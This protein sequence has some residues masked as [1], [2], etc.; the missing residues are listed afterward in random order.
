MIPMVSQGMRKTRVGNPLK[1][2]FI[3]DAGGDLR[4]RFYQELRSKG[5]RW[6]YYTAPYHWGMFNPESRKIVTYTEGD[7]AEITAP[8][9][10]MFH[11]EIRSY[12]KWAKDQG[13]L[14][15]ETTDY[16]KRI[17]RKR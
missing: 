5:Y 12:A 13:E 4:I 2:S 15:S 1:D 6:I 8:N 14:D 10:Q 3:M 9:T 11:R 7:V 17:R 16:L